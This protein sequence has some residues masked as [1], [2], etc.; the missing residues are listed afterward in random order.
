[1]LKEV[2]I[3]RLNKIVK[4]LQNGKSVYNVLDD[5]CTIVSMIKSNS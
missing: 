3:A 1:M 5:L 2:L 4:E